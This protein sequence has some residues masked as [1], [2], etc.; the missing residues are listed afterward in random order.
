MKWIVIGWI[1]IV[2]GVTYPA[3]VGA[4]F[5]GSLASEL[6]VDVNWVLFTIC[7]LIGMAGCMLKDKGKRD[8]AKK[9]SL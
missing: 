1:L 6:P 7:F 9:G 3:I 5:L 8:R 2:I 4:M